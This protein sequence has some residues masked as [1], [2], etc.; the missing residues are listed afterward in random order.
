MPFPSPG[1]PPLRAVCTSERE[2]YSDGGKHI[3]HE[4]NPY[5]Y[6]GVDELADSMVHERD[7]ASFGKL[8]FRKEAIT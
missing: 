4:Q 7:K 1:I 5:S 6:N 3:S 8:R 2:Q